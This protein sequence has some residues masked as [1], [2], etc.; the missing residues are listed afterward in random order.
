MKRDMELARSI[1]LQ[2][3]KSPNFKS[4]IDMKFDGFSDE[5]VSYHIML[6]NE[7]GLIIALNLSSGSDLYWIPERLTWQGNE[8]IEASRNTTAWNK[9]KEIMNKSGGFVFEI[10]KTIL[11]EIIKNQLIVKI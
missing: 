11:I 10:A 2:I 1:L 5:E 4:S 9:T 6:L 8:F 3:E 7:G